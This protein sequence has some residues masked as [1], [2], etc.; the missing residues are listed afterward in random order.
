MMVL[1][2]SMAS[3]GTC[4]DYGNGVVVCDGETF[5]VTY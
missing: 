2:A 5:T 3:A 4:I 1:I